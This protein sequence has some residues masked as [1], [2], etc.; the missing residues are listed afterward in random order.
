[1]HRIDLKNLTILVVLSIFGF[2]LTSYVLST[3]G[4]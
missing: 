1:M 2:Y 3:L 4:D